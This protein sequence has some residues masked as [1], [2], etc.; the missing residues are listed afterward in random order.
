[1]R[2]MITAYREDNDDVEFKFIHVFARIEMC[3]KWS[4]TRLTLSKGKFDPDAAPALAS[5]GRLISA[6]KLCDAAAL[7]CS[8]DYD[9]LQRF[10]TMGSSRL[11]FVTV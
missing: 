10:A 6:A 7:F 8:L 1:M 2:A 9:D 5:D 11:W 3:D 4:E